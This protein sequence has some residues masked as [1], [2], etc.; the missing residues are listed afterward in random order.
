MHNVG[1]KQHM[2]KTE[3]NEVEKPEMEDGYRSKYI[4][5]HI[6]AAWL[7][8]VAD[9]SFLLV[10]EQGETGQQEDEQTENQHQHPPDFACGGK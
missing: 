10:T 5:T 9:K 3:K 1:C 4:E 2:G 8:G 7:D 6:G